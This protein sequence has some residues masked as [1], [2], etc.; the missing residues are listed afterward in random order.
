[1]LEQT[2]TCLR[3]LKYHDEPVTTAAWAP[4]GKTFVTGSLD[5]QKPLTIWPA[6]LGPDMKPLHNFEGILLRVQ[7]CAIRTVAPTFASAAAAQNNASGTEATLPVRMVVVTAGAN[8][9]FIHVFDYTQRVRLAQIS[10]V[11]DITCLNL[12]QDGHEMLLNLSS[13]EVWAISVDTCDINQK[14]R[15]QKQGKFVIKS[16]YGGANEGCVVSG[17]EGKLF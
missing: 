16:C 11:H 10:M 12:S 7:D 15:G 2:G 13:G 4:D 17:G 14:F 3:T 6:D 1:M 8:E 5:V 9:K